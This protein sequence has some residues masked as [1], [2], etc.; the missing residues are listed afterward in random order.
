VA[1]LPA[2][3]SE[4]RFDLVILADLLFNH[5]EHRKLVK[6]VQQALKRKQD[7]CALV[8]FTPYRPWL[9]EKDLAFFDLARASGFN[10]SKI[11]ERVMDKVL[12]E[13][14]PGVV[15]SSSSS[16]IKLTV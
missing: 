2:S 15:L 3:D 9:L 14:D 7:A 6:S 1:H 12:F 13:K 11:F 4:R 8:F 5:S 16:Q 10:V